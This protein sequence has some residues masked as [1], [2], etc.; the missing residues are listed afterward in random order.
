MNNTGSDAGIVTSLAGQPQR[1]YVIS[2]ISNLGDQYQDPNRKSTPVGTVGVEYTEKF[3][4][5]GKIMDDFAAC[6]TFPAA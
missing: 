2:V 4:K 6:H 5:L 1:H 3:A